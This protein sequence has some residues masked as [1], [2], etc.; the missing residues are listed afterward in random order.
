[1]Q[2]SNLQITREPSE[3]ESPSPHQDKPGLI[4]LQPPF[5][6]LTGV[7]GAVLKPAN[8]RAVR[9]YLCQAE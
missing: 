6:R 5:F 2:N 7:D 8:M 4:G 1:M 9:T 3:N